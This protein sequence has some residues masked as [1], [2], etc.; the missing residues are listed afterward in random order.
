VKDVEILTHCL[1]PLKQLSTS[2]L[3]LEVEKTEYFPGELVRG[4]VLYTPNKE[5]TVTG[6]YIRFKGYEHSEWQEGN[7]LKK[8]FIISSSFIFFVH[9]SNFLNQKFFFFSSNSLFLWRIHVFLRYAIK[10]LCLFSL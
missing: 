6:V 1:A 7:R 3:S 2:M 9:H 4:R 8:L 10:S 5:Q